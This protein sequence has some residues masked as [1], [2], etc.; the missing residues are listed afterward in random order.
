MDDDDDHD[1]MQ[2]RVHTIWTTTDLQHIPDLIL[3]LHVLIPFY[4]SYFS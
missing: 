2:L 1:I 4:T 3:K